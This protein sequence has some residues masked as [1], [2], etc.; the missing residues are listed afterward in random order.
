MGKESLPDGGTLVLGGT[1]KTGRRVAELLHRAGRRL[2]IG[3]RSAQPP[4]DWE[5]PETW[6][7]ALEGMK[8]AYITYQPD[9]SLPGALEALQMFFTAAAARGVRKLV[10]LSARKYPAAQEVERALQAATD[11]WTSLRAGWFNQNFSEYWLLG[12][13]LAGALKLPKGLASEPF[14]DADDIAEVAFAALTEAG[15]SR[16]IYELTGPRALSFG[17]AVAEIALATG[18]KIDFL[19]L[20]E[21]E[22]RAELLRQGMP[23]E[24]HDS[25][26][27]AFKLVDG[28]NTAVCDGVSRALGR[29]PR[30]FSEYARRAAATG[31]WNK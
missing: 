5:K 13:I 22:Y 26:L 19:A 2:R 3:S 10:F 18:R 30:D 6:E 15:H 31:V 21:A 12:P 17:E 23:A 24:Y 7:P 4:Y 29:A 8:A 11:D 27:D 25:V 9:V 1:G 16:Q 20:S 28:R 14:V